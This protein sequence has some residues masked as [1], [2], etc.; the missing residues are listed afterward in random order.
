[1]PI[2]TE[3]AD[4]LPLGYVPLGS[5]PWPINKEED[6]YSVAKRF[7]LDVNTLIQFNFQTTNPDEV[8]WYLRRNVGCKKAT[9]DGLNWMFS[10]DAFPGIIYIS[11]P[12]ASQ[13]VTPAAS[14]E[15]RLGIDP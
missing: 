3:P 6:W 9:K 13:V 10:S 5:F 8:N 1:M 7:S 15:S 14:L 11:L 4:P 12:H 2:E